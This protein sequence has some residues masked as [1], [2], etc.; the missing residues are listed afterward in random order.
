MGIQG[1]IVS[2]L[3]YGEWIRIILWCLIYNANL[4]Y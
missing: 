4:K 3:T 2:E 1:F